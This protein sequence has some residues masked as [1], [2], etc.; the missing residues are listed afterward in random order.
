M[1]M[2]F[3][4]RVF[5]HRKISGV[6]RYSGA[7]LSELRKIIDVDVFTPASE[8]R[9]AQHLW[10][11][12]RLP[13]DVL[14]SRADVLFC[15][16]MVGP[17]MLPKSIPLVVTIHDLAFLRFP[18]MYARA[19]REYYRF[20]LP[21][22]LRRADL[23]VALTQVE[24][25]HIES[26]YPFA[27]NKVHVV[28]SGVEEKFRVLTDGRQPIILAVGSLNKHK[29]LSALIRG[30][31]LVADRIA[32][33]LVIVGGDRSVISSDSG[34][35]EA[36]RGLPASRVS[37]LGYVSD[38]ELLSWYGKAD[39]FAFPSLFEGF[40]LPPLEAMA[41]GCAVVAS[42]ASCI[43][44]VCGDGA[45][46]F[47]PLSDVDIGRALLDMSCD[48]ELKEGVR[49]RGREHSKKYSWSNTANEMVRLIGD[50]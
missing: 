25:E 46:Y 9:H 2:A 16:V 33:N 20:I 24:S 29:N 26:T 14:T 38:D 47:D 6:E 36:L 4:G 10:V 11:Q 50:I 43:P 35:G 12:T 1:K 40:G 13:V 39:I 5:K 45:Y 41:A 18:D 19:F 31:S 34:I 30:F 23:I 32:H 37:M 44:E 7:L 42:N 28:P 27:R 17:V 49:C 48:S 8:H 15:P 21:Y 3:D 22:V